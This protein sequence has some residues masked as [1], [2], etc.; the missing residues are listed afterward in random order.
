MFFEKM[1]VHILVKR[2][3]LMQNES[4]FVSILSSCTFVDVGVVLY[5]G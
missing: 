2:G 5:A 1:M 3:L 4:T